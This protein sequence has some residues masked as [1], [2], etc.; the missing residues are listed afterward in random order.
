[1]WVWIRDIADFL[2][3]LA[4]IATAVVAVWAGGLFLWQARAR[5]LKLEGYLLAQQGGGD[6]GMRSIL[7]LMSNLAMTEEQIYSAAFASD[8]VTAVPLSNERGFAEDILF[9]HQK[10][11]PGRYSPR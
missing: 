5:R 3:N 6:Q 1:M 8:T 10:P 11:R 2:S 9:L 7:H 4:A